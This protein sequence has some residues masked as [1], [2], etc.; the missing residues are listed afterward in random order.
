MNLAGTDL[1]LLLVFDAVMTERNATRAGRKIGMSQPA[2]SNALN[3]LRHLMK[4]DLFVRGPE[5]MRPTARA[6][7]LEIPIRRA[8]GEIEDALSPMAFDPGKAERTFTIATTDYVAMT[9]LPYIAGYITNEAP[10]VNIH[11]VPIEGRMFEKLDHQE[12][13]YG[14]TALS[15]VPDRFGRLSISSDHFVCMMRKDHPLAAYK[16]QIPAEEYA[17]ARHVLVS[18]R[19]DAHGFVDDQLADMGLKRRIVMM[20]NNFGSAP[21]LVASSDMVVTMPSRVADK[22]SEFF[23]LH[24]VPSP[25]SPPSHMIGGVLVWH[26]RLTNHPAHTWFRNLMLRAGEDL[27][28]HGVKMPEPKPFMVEGMPS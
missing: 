8:L 11:T 18:P 13:D 16:D 1:N 9:L 25:I 24:I 10:G 2:V 26:K 14:L 3:R 7:E 17:A 6:L 15:D 22:C 28:T 12:A 27:T 5:G 4:D 23:D 19:G 21:M 20:V